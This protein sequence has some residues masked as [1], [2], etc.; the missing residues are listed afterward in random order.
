MNKRDWDDSVPLV[1]F[2]TREAVQE[3]L[4]FSPAELVFGHEVRGPLK[5]L[6]ELVVPEKKVKS[7]PDYVNKLRDRLHLACSL[8]REA[9][10]SSQ[11]RMKKR[12]DQQAVTFVYAR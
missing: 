2:A 5:V 3:S 10:N 12:Y 8:A 6:K 1:M 4:G 11:A 7:I 9:L